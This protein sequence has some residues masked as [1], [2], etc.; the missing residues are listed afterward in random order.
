MKSAISIK[1]KS[2]WWILDACQ[3]MD[4]L[5]PTSRPEGDGF[6]GIAQCWLSEAQCSL[7]TEEPWAAI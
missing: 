5:F 6:V 2:G 7:I 4:D 3:I 1:K